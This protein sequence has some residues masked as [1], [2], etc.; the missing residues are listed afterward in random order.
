[1]D[2]VIRR[3]PVRCLSGGD[4]LESKK[5]ANRPS[6]AMDIEFLEK[7]RDLGLI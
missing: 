5:R 4:L 7:K 3:F 6:D 2:E 1:M